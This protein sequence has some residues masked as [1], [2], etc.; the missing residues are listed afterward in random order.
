MGIPNGKVVIKKSDIGPLEG[1]RFLIGFGD[2]FAAMP[3]PRKDFLI[4]EG[5]ELLR[6]QE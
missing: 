1:Y 5:A 6:A 4:I 3:W 2:D